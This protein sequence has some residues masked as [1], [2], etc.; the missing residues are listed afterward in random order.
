MVAISACPTALL[1]GLWE[2]LE[3]ALRTETHH[4]DRLMCPG[5][6]LNEQGT[7]GFFPS[8]ADRIVLETQGRKT[9]L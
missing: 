3:V 1:Q 2:Q 6:C 7:L 8:N 4:Q 9:A 5:G